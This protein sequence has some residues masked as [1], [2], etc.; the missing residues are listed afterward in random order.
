MSEYRIAEL[1]RYLKEYNLS[2]LLITDV[3][4]AE[5][6]SGFRSSNVFLLISTRRNILFTDFRYKDAAIQFCGRNSIWRFVEI[7]NS[8]FTFLQSFLKKNNRVGIQSDSIT[9]DQFEQMKKQLKKVMFV[10]LGSKVSRV[11]IVKMKHEISAMQQAASIGDKA[12][13]ML[14]RRIEIGMTEKE[15]ANIL[16]NLC[17]EYGSERPPFDTIVLFGARAA[18]P[19]GKPSNRKVKPGDWILCDFGCTVGGFCSDM[20]RTVIMGKADERQ[21]SIYSIVLQAQENA[22][23]AIR[24]GIKTYEVDKS[25]RTVIKNAGYG[26]AFGHGTGHGIGLSIHEMPRVSKN[27]KTVL[28]KNMVM[29]IEPGIYIKRFGGVRIEDMVVITETG[30]RSLTKS[31]RKLLEI[32]NYSDV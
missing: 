6:I 26:D 17:R 12:F 7:K 25:A 11:S 27:D 18:L 3:I 8:D 16:E 2:H 22:K 10:K 21:K 9:L 30:F 1:K 14:I 4:S 5:Y 31:P 23:K 13:G 32:K 29:T 24:A 19:H 20:T 28:L 15:V